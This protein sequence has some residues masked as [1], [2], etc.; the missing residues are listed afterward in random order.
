ME[1]TVSVSE[2]EL[3]PPSN[4][5]IDC[6]SPVTLLQIEAIPANGNYTYEWSSLNGQ[7]ESDPYQPAIE[8][9]AGGLY[10]V[11]VTDE[12][13]C[14]ETE[15]TFV[16]EYLTLPELDISGNDEISCADP[17]TSLFVN[18]SETVNGFNWIL[19]DGS[20]ATGNSLNTSQAGWHVV[21]GENEHGCIGKDSLFVSYLNT[22]FTYQVAISG[23]LTC[24]DTLQSITVT[25]NSA[26]DSIHWS[27]PGIVS[28]SPGQT[29]IMVNQEGY[30]G[31]TFYQ[32]EAC[33]YTD[34]AFVALSPPDIQYT[35]TQPDTLTCTQTS[36]SLSVL[37]QPVNAV[38]W[39]LAGIPIAYTGLTNVNEP[40][41]YIFQITDAN[42][43][44]LQDTISVGT[45]YEL[46]IAIV[47]TD[48][49]DCADNKGGFTLDSTNALSFYWVDTH[50]VPLYNELQPEFSEEGQYTLVLT[51]N[52]GCMN[53]LPY[54]LPS[55]K[56]YP[57]ILT[58]SNTIT[59]LNPTGS[60]AIST[61][62][63]S[64]INWSSDTGTAG[65]SDLIQSNKPG[66]YTITAS[67]AQGCTAT[68][69][70]EIKIDTLSPFCQAT[71]SD[72]LNCLTPYIKPE[73]TASGYVRYQWTGPGLID[74]TLMPA[75]D[76]SGTYTLQ[77]TAANGCTRVRSI[78]VNEDYD[79]P[80]FEI[81]FGELSCNAPET[82]L[83]MQGIE[84]YKY[85]LQT[86]NGFIPITSGHAID[87]PGLY[88]IRATGKNGCDTSSQIAVIGH[89][90]KPEVSID[91]VKLNC[92]HPVDTLYN[93]IEANQQLNYVWKVNGQ[94]S[95][96]SSAIV[97]E[98]TR[99]ILKATNMYGCEQTDSAHIAADFELP[100]ASISPKT[101][102]P[103]DDNKVTVSVI[104]P[105]P[106]YNFQWLN[107]TGNALG[108]ASSM[109]LNLT[110]SYQ[111]KTTN[112]T[113][114]CEST[115]T[116]EVTKQLGP[117]KLIFELEQPRCYGDIATVR[118]QEVSGGEAPYQLNADGLKI[119]LQQTTNQSSGKHIL[120]A[121]D[122]NGCETDTQ[123][124]VDYV[125]PFSVYAGED[126]TI[127]LFTSHTLHADII[128]NGNDI[129]E[130]QWTPDYQLSCSQCADPEVSP[131]VTTAY[132]IQITNQNGCV[133]Q[134][135]VL[136]RVRFDKGVTM[137]NIIRPGG[138]NGHF[139]LYSRYNSIQTI[140]H[141]RIFD[142]WGNLIFTRTDFDPDQIDLGWDGTFNSTSVAP[143]VYVWTAA[144][145]YRDGSE[146]VLVGDVTVVK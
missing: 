83:S 5:M 123:F 112:T 56:N 110:G 34:V 146:E 68:V 120:K 140:N 144:L 54:Y 9:S 90:E 4:G 79:K 80:Q 86:T 26:Y 127:Q 13:G 75:I 50:Q 7:I 118:I 43:C 71:I 30:Y 91:A 1:F 73:V 65:N 84:S 128:S 113:N 87:S 97:N 27:G 116:F 141:L 38:T 107:A 66:N 95:Y 121:I 47:L 136:V 132:I 10:L 42:G 69:T 103:C 108:T 145:T 22:A 12:L 52:N 46:P 93:T 39:Y 67:T 14:E 137:P 76:R 48:T 138:S 20:T 82:K 133:E 125:Y 134:D 32:G 129:K 15:F 31:Y 105:N 41:D 60:I 89:F 143:G 55:D 37:T 122:K 142:R 64:Q 100:I 61:T 45:N 62:L 126:T 130:I 85:A 8:V 40:G 135:M 77:V 72:T 17:E 119:Q 6:Y 58:S 115:L 70:A 53:T 111:L 117:D 57:A 94:V 109:D 131:E 124:T 104:N 102:I 78:Y 33:T 101:L 139:T 24:R 18:A 23:P 35:T 11:T 2:L 3:L 21:S 106:E 29:E 28:I 59:C 16:D 88:T 36:V 74:T 49:I 98:E 114:G 51:G 96:A 25:L 92:L 63:P 19:P 44:T 99:V 81:L